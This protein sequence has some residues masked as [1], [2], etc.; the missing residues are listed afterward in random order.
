[1][2][3]NEKRILRDAIKHVAH[4]NAYAWW[5]LKRQIFEGGFQ[6]YYPVQGDFDEPAKRAID[7][8]SKEERQ[9]L[10]AEWRKSAGRDSAFNEKQILETYARMI[11]EEVVARASVAAYRTIH[12]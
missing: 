4:H 12:W 5:D 10:L 9:D 7:R 3:K 8:L 11:V 6:S 2:T 1:M